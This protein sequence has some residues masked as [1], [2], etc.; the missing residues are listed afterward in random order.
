MVGKGV[1]LIVDDERLNLDMLDTILKEAEFESI[2]ACD[3][4]DALE[5]L[6]KHSPFDVII[7]DWM[8]PNMDGIQ[9]LKKLKTDER[10]CEIP[11]IMQT[12]LGNPQKVHEAREA[13]AFSYLVKPYTEEA[14][15]NAVKEAQHYTKRKQQW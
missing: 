14:I 7:L 15:L 5:K 1:V 13:G 3:G 10:Y 2:Q 12:A 6:S 8:M 11:V 9:L 4:I